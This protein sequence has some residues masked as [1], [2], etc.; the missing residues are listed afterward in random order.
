[1]TQDDWFRNRRW[2]D[3]IEAAFFA[4]LSRSRKKSQYIRIQACELAERHPKVALRLLDQ[5]FASLTSAEPYEAVDRAAAYH[6]RAS[7][8]LALGD[9][10]AAIVSYEDALA[11]EAE[12]PNS[13]T[14]AYVGLPFLIATRRLQSYYDRALDILR[15]HGTRPKLPI[16][17]FRWNAAQTL[18]SDDLGRSGDAQAFAT[19]ALAA[20]RNHSGFRYHRTIGLVRDFDP[21]VHQRLEHLAQRGLL[22]S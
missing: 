3:A 21:E 17:Q 2:D 13:R 19:N 16:E 7:A 1:M 20:A 14:Q 15:E 12:F 11:R 6:H 22:S 5:Y 9:T 8:H 18:I 4:R 10:E